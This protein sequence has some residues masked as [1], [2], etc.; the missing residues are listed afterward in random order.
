MLMKVTYIHHSCFLAETESCY[1]LFDY[2][3]GELPE[4]DPQ[5]PILVLASHKHADHYHPSVFSL[6]KDMGMEQIHAVLSRDISGR[7]VPKDIP[8]L[9]V[10]SRRTYSL[11]QGQTLS[12]FLST[13][14][15]VAFLIRDKEECFYHAGYLNDWVWE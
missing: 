11:P 9:S 10:S 13:D 1:Y 2:F 4:L 12:T 8:L 15:G 3:K 5:K 14:K 6:L 7:T